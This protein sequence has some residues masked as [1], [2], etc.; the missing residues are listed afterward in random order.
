MMVFKLQ[1][2]CSNIYIREIEFLIWRWRDF[3]GIPVFFD[4]GTMQHTTALAVNT[5]TII[6]HC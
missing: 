1:I 6:S 5:L 2:N 3:G 4:E